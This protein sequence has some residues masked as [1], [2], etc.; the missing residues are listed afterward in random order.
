MLVNWV[1]GKHQEVAN[2]K[3]MLTINQANAYDK[4]VDMWTQKIM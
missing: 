3:T 1:P 2:V 4:N